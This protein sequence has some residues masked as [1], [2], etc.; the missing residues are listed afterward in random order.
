MRKVTHAAGAATGAA[1]GVVV[2]LHS[3]CCEV[4]CRILQRHAF[5][6]CHGYQ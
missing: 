4:T 5:F 6:G 2:L 1:A 3:M